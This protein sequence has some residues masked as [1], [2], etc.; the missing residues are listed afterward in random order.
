MKLNKLL[1]LIAT[2]G[3]ASVAIPLASCSC[4][5]VNYRY[6][7][8]ENNY[9]EFEPEY[10]I[11]SDDEIT[12][13]NIAQIF[14]NEVNQN[15]KILADELV[16]RYLHENA[17]DVIPEFDFINYDV[18]V[19]NCEAQT[20]KMSFSVKE[21]YEVAEDEQNNVFNKQRNIRQINIEVKNLP[22]TLAYLNDQW[23]L[24]PTVCQYLYNLG[25]TKGEAASD[26]FISYLTGH[27]DWEIKYTFDLH[28][29][30]AETFTITFNWQSNENEFNALYRYMYES[31]LDY[32][33][34]ELFT[35]T[36]VWCLDEI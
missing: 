30:V 15:K 28:D 1:P 16:Y 11:E 31:D 21:T 12:E 6:E 26:S 8:D 32:L 25:E 29:V 24:R 4:G 7:F 22:Y 35:V 36:H 9:V 23:V 33:G 20:W 18:S 2:T 17:P 27:H 14:F 34:N 19:G 13:K 10:R 3:I 5:V